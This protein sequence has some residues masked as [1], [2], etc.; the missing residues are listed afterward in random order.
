VQRPSGIATLT[1]RYVEEAG[2]RVRILDTRKTTP[3][4]RV[5]ERYAVRC[6]G[7]STR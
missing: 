4:L 5:L 7:C 6:G 3:G 1:A 2:G